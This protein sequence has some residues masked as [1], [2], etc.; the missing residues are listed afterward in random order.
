MELNSKVDKRLNSIILKAMHAEIDKRYKSVDE[1]HKAITLYEKGENP[2]TIHGDDEIEE[3]LGYFTSDRLSEAE[4]EFIKLVDKYPE[5]PR[6][7]LILGEIYSRCHKFSDAIK[8]YNKGLKLHPDFG[9]LIRNLGL[10][11]SSQDNFEN[12]IKYMKLAIKT[13]AQPER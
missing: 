3:A 7:F 11:Y 8:T 9:L 2:Q 12:A 6:V 5:N 13:R 4:K 10:C 1:F